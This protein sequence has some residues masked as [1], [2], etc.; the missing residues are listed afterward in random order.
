MKKLKVFLTLTIVSII[1]AVSPACGMLKD[2]EAIDGE[3]FIEFM[4]DE[5][6]D[7]E[8]ITDE[9]LEEDVIEAAIIAYTDDYQ[10]EF[11]IFKTVD[12]AKNAFNQNRNNFEEEKGNSSSYTEV[13]FGNYSKYSQKSNGKY[14]V[15]SRIENTFIYLETDD[16]YQDEIKEYLDKLGY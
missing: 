11:Y 14:S 7:V 2:K 13:S 6:L 16:K 10:I 5:G 15:V 9:Y 1:L 3:E 8:D 12:H 4:E